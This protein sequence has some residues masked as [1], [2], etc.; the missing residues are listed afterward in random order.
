MLRDKEE[1]E[2]EADRRAEGRRV[3]AIASKT[4]A[5]KRSRET[6][7][8]IKKNKVLKALKIIFDFSSFE[9]KPILDLL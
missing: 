2:R 3:S 7:M 6:N 1:G 9:K 8:V 4:G 5:E